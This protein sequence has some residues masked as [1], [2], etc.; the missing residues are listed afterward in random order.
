MGRIGLSLSRDL[1]RV[2]YLVL[3]STPRIFIN[4]RILNFL[5]L[6]VVV[7]FVVFVVG[8]SIVFVIGWMSSNTV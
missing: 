6:F 7:V 2:S 4:S 5:F 1:S 8:F 3:L